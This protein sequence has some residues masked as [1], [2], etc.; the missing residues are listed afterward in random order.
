MIDALSTRPARIVGIEA[1]RIREG[2]LAELVLIDPEAIL[3]SNKS[4]SGQRVEI[5]RS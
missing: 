3:K 4:R 2:A 5:H 1:P